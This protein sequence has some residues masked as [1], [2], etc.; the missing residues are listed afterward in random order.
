[1]P[2]GDE[3]LL[4]RLRAAFRDE[5][6][7]H[8]EAIASGLIVME[9]GD[10][11]ARTNALEA[12]YRAAHSLKGAARTVNI[13]SVE[14][15]C[16]ALESVFGAFK[17]DAAQTSPE[18]FDLLQRAA[19]ALKTLLPD[20]IDAPAKPLTPEVMA[21]VQALRGSQTRGSTPRPTVPSP[22]PPPTPVAKPAAPDAPVHTTGDR[23]RPSEETVRVSLN[24]LESM[25]ERLEAFLAV[26]LTSA[27]RSRQVRQ[28]VQ[29]PEAWRRR[30]S[31]ARGLTRL[32]STAE[33]RGAGGSRL[34]EFL[35][36]N[37]A[38]HSEFESDLLDL[39]RAT[40]RDE[41]TIASLTDRLLDELKTFVLQPCSSLFETVPLLVR[42][43]SRRGGKE[44]ELV[45]D[46]GEVDLDR[47]ILEE[48][49]DP[50]I[51]LVRNSLDHGIEKPETRV[52][53]GKSRRGTLRIAAAPL[54]GS[55]VEL[56]VETTAGASISIG[57]GRSP[58]N[59]EKFPKTA[60]RRSRNR[61]RLA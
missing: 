7:E 9:A 54:E 31:R 56:I 60:R 27:Q 3:T 50:L 53:A 42:D 32:K 18:L 47:R 25:M 59:L 51:H 41:H 45:L 6:R 37:E 61:R 36:W 15:V 8:V 19:A 34:N 22:P 21:I 13:P 2:S 55:N 20:D 33:S 39:D 48:L 28:L 38:F 57:F 14:S 52:A 35:E 29:R 30:W 43:L 17:R 44:V 46:G 12:V 11:A 10:P 24:R 40:R 5:A 23:P 58:S 1:M 16:Q 4:R 26:R 49:K